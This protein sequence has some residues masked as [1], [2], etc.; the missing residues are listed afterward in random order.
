VLGRLLS[1]G[2][3]SGRFGSATGYWSYNSTIS[4]WC[5]AGAHPERTITWASYAAE[6]G[7]DPM[8]WPLL[9]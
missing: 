4:Y 5:P 8:S 7:I 6:N 9:R 3:L 1:H 2:E